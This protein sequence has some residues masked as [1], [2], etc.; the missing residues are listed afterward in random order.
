MGYSMGY[1]LKKMV[2]K[3]LILEGYKDKILSQK[4]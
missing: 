3:D 4:V 2:A 1:K